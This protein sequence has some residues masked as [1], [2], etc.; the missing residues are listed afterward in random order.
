MRTN[1]TLNKSFPTNNTFIITFN[2]CF[3]INDTLN[4]SFRTIA[5]PN[6]SFRT[7]HTFN[8]SFRT[9]DTLNKSFRIILSENSVIPYKILKSRIAEET[10]PNT[11]VIFFHYYEIN[12]RRGYLMIP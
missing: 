2:K 10:K 3:R 9:N 12:I 4:K 5:T 8:K 11:D 7:N 1:D 6:K